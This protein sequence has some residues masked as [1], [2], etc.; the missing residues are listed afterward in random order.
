[1]L[2]VHTS[3]PVTQ[4]PRIFI[5]AFS[6]FRHKAVVDDWVADVVEV[7]DIQGPLLDENCFYS[8]AN[9]RRQHEL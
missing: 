8:G 9:K 1:M 5:D 4:R 2:P 7:Q 3:L 6:E